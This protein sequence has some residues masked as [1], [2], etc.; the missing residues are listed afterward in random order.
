MSEMPMV[1]REKVSR[2]DLPEFGYE[3]ANLVMAE[4]HG[5]D[6][7]GFEMEPNYMRRRQIEDAFEFYGDTTMDQ[8]VESAL[9]NLGM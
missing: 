8:Y 4:E 1:G 7:L 9:Q 3:Y 6:A 5:I 2:E